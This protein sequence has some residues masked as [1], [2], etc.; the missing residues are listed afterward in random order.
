MQWRT[1][2]YHPHL[3]INARADSAE[4][5]TTPPVPRNWQLPPAT[6]VPPALR[7]AVGGIPWWPGCWPS[8]SGTNANRGNCL[9]RNLSGQSK[10]E[11][12]WGQRLNMRMTGS[13]K[14]KAPPTCGWPESRAFA[15]LL[16][17]PVGH[18]RADSHPVAER[19]QLP[20]KQL[21]YSIMQ[22][23]C[24]G[25]PF[26]SFS[27]YWTNHLFPFQ[28]G[29]SLRQVYGIGSRKV[30]RT[31]FEPAWMRDPTT[32]QV[33]AYAISPPPHRM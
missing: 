10:P 28:A 26:L 15:P 19:Y 12:L 8:A 7:E 20:A 21:Y 4:T 27:V 18:A 2:G 30:G 22:S 31:G 25:L 17:F 23:F 5:G 16:C 14:R 33:V 13:L 11:D 1:A 29:S 32:W 3:R 24:Q 9:S 6:D